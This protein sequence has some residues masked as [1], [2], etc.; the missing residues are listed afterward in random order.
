MKLTSSSISNKDYGAFQFILRQVLKLKFFA[1]KL[2]RFKEIK[3]TY[4]CGHLVVGFDWIGQNIFFGNFENTE[5]LILSNFI[6]NNSVVID[7][8]ANIGFHTVFFASKVNNG[9][10]YSF[11]PSSRE[12][13]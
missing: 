13:E 12:F 1:F 10:I 5:L 7:V 6:N 4:P 11:E 8:G 2:V 3:R 9:F